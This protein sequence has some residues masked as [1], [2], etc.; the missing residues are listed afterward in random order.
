M[1]GNKMDALFTINANE[2]VAVT[3]D[4]P[5]SPRIE[6]YVNLL[7]T[8]YD[9]VSKLLDKNTTEL[10][11]LRTAHDSDI[12]RINEA[13]NKAAEDRDFCTEYEEWI[14]ELSGELSHYSS[15]TGRIFEYEVAVEVTR[16]F[17][18]TVYVTVSASS[19]ED[20]EE[21][22]KDEAS[23][24]VDDVCDETYDISCTDD[25]EYEV[26]SVEKSR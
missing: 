16:T 8:S 12:T 14:E 7:R 22:V 3:K 15:L 10:N 13:L 1:K 9:E 2:L 4:H 19:E 20:A 21:L 18:S 5:A 24:I 23:S 11:K 25:V 26:Q 6:H 17:K